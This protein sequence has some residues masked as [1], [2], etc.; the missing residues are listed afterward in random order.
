MVK[1]VRKKPFRHIRLIRSLQVYFKCLFR[2]TFNIS[3]FSISFWFC[4]RLSHT[5][6]LSNILLTCLL[7]NVA[8]DNAEN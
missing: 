4:G 1:R 2:L 5:I 8:L 7:G 6:T 3:Y